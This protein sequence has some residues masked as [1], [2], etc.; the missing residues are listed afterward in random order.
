MTTI[1]P[2]PSAGQP[3]NIPR[4][5][6]AKILEGSEYAAAIM[7]W[8]S[9]GPIRFADDSE[10]CAL[11]DAHLNGA[12]AAVT[13]APIDKQPKRIRVDALQLGAYS[14]AADGRCPWLGIDLDG[15]THGSNALID[16]DRAAAAIAERAD[17]FG[18][19]DGVLIVKSRSGSGRHV[20]I[21]PPEPIP[22]AEACAAIAFLAAAAWRI[23]GRDVQE[24]ECRSAFETRTGQIAAPGQA[25]AFELI[26]KS[27]DRPDRGYV[28]AMPFGGVAARNGGGVA[29]DV[30]EHPVR[31]IEPTCV[32]RCRP[33]LWA[34]FLGEM[35][36]TLARTKRPSRPVQ[37]VRSRREWKLDPRTQQLIAGAVPEGGRNKAVYYGIGDLIRSGVP[38]PEAVRLIVA[39][40]M[41]C[42]VKQR[43]AEA[44]IRSALRRWAV[45]R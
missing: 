4:A 9:F 10:R 19:L 36:A 1:Y 37:P 26:P 7:P 15:A 17:A 16:P 20:W 32:P 8:G 30:F 13:F 2:I 23:A 25:G 5:I 12:P 11:I 44:T 45:R 21:F 22:I 42:G 24:H 31:A 14:P 28:L 33:E 43:E 38:E 40:A 18:I 39:G 6:L 34:R 29:V 41:R 3:G 35:R 27:T